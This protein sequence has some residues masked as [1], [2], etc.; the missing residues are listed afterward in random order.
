MDMA[1]LRS[2]Y[3]LPPDPPQEASQPPYVPDPPRQYLFSKYGI[4]H[5]DARSGGLTPYYTK[6]EHIAGEIQYDKDQKAVVA[7]PTKPAT[8]QTKSQ[9]AQNQST[10][11]SQRT[12]RGKQQRQQNF[13]QSP[14]GLKQSTGGGQN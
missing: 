5:K 12:R 9:E 10:P 4:H 13:R 3:Q 7:T 2:A 14:T 11:M 6:D 8:Q 1:A